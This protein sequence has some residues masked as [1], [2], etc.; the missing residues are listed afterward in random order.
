MRNFIQDGNVVTLVAPSGGVLAGAGILVGGLFGVAATS[1]AEG[2]DVEASVVGVFDLV[3]ATGAV[4]AGAALYWD[5][6][7]KKV[8]GTA[9]GNTLVGVALKAAGSSDPTARIRLNGTFGSASLAGLAALDARVV[10]LEE[11]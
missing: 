9:T 4:S 6:A 5:A 7:A 3:K 2:A 1:A 11:A 8:T 10:A